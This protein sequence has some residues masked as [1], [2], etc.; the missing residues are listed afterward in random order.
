MIQV[1]KAMILLHMSYLHIMVIPI[2][3]NFVVHHKYI[4]CINYIAKLSGKLLI[5]IAYTVSYVLW[6]CYY[7][8]WIILTWNES[9]IP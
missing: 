6:L 2:L 5:Y 7:M 1:L 8:H 4:D 9:L 3:H